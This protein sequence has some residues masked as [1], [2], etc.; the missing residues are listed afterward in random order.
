MLAELARSALSAGRWPLGALQ[1][2]TINTLHVHCALRRDTHP[3]VDTSNRQPS[4]WERVD[5]THFYTLWF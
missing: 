3:C 2:Q 4:S 1:L 5:W